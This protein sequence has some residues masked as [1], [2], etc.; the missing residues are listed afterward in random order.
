MLARTHILFSI[1]LIILI[2]KYNFIPVGNIWIFSIVV[3][4]FTLLPDIDTSKSFFGRKIW[5]LSAI[6]KYTAGHR[7]FFHSI[8][9]PIIF[10][11]TFTLFGYQDI[12]YAS[13]IGY[14]SHLFTDALTKEGITPFYPF[15]FRIKGFFKTNGIIELIFAV[16]LLMIIITL[17]F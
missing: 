10:F 7:T 6:I 15:P 2:D 17:L 8:Y 13:L 1:L 14:C 11:L 4:F 16:F 5:P 3:L 9:I 12:A